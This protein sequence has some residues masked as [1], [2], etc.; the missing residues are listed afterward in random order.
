MT[1]L[2]D[3]IVT[4]LEAH[5][6]TAALVAERIYAVR[7]EQG[8]TP[9]L[10]V[11]QVISET[12]PS[13]MGSDTGNVRARVQIDSY[14]ADYDAARALSEQVRAALQRYSATVASVQIDDIQ[15]DDDSGED[16]FEDEVE[17][18]RVRQDYLIWYRE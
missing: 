5:A 2:G 6:G 3:A 16:T 7:A 10:I 13:A 15:L 4:R 12:R 14:A 1:V 11:Y 8:A 9:P 17:L 18:Y